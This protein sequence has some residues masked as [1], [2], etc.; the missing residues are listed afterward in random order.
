M[1][2]NQRSAVSAHQVQAVAALRR[3]HRLD[4]LLADL[5]QHRVLVVRQQAGDIVFPASPPLRL[6]I[7]AAIR[8]SVS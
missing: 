6:S 8:S 7:T 3:E 2:W 1:Q 4:G 5:L